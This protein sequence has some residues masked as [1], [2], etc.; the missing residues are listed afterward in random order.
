MKTDPVPVANE[1]PKIPLPTVSQINADRITLLGVVYYELLNPSETITGTLYRTQLIRLSRGLKEKRPQYYSRHDKVILLHDN[2]RPGSVKNY[3]KTLDWEILLH[4]P[5]SPDIAPSDCHLFQAMAHAL[6]EQRFISYEDIKNWVDSWIASKDKE[7]F[8]LGIECCLKDGKNDDS[9]RDMRGADCLLLF[10]NHCFGSME[11]QLQRSGQKIG[12]SQYVDKFTRR[13]EKSRVQ[14]DSK[15]AKVLEGYTEKRQ[16]RIVREIEL[17]EKI[18]TTA[19]DKV[20]TNFRKY[21]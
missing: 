2:G 11:V 18:L 19:H 21:T 3:L 13:K 5:S 10:L 20:H 17:G 8:R 15:M 16:A 4:P 9:G 7:F 12:F 6:L 14:S 1:K